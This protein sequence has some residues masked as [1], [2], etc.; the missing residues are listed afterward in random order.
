[1]HGSRDGAE[2][3]PTA[4]PQLGDELHDR[5]RGDAL[6]PRPRAAALQRE[7][8]RSYRHLVRAGSSRVQCNRF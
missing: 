1:M 5:V 4:G 6:V 8:L 2:A 3:L 7:L